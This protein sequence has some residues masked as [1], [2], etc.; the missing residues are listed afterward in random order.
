MQ[1]AAAQAVLSMSSTEPAQLDAPLVLAGVAVGQSGTLYRW[2]T[3]RLARD[4]ADLLCA[5][6]Q[7]G[8]T[9]DGGILDS[10]RNCHDDL[11]DFF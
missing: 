10:G 3:H 8:D 11:P 7:F 6:Q 5:P 4:D 9:R 2:E 1:A